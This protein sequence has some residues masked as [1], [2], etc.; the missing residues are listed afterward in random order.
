MAR[1]EAQR[2]PL[3]H[4]SSPRR[5][6]CR[7]CTSGARLLTISAAHEDISYHFPDGALNRR[8]L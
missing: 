7:D 5:R 8:T 1:E 4:E 6:V 3:R 2:E